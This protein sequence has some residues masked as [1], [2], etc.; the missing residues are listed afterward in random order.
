VRG[1]PRIFIGSATKIHR[2]NRKQVLPPFGRCDAGRDHT[3]FFRHAKG[4]GNRREIGNSA[5]RQ[6]DTCR[7][8]PGRVLR[9]IVV[10]RDGVALFPSSLP[11]SGTPPASSMTPVSGNSA[12][13]GQDGY[14][15]TGP[16]GAVSPVA[17]RVI[18][19]RRGRSPHPRPTRQDST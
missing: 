16:V 4:K 9:P 17:A 19:S 15:P 14:G 13:Q 5:T 11:P 18:G 7:I 1:S 10:T 8:A 12:G 6:A 3:F 2:L